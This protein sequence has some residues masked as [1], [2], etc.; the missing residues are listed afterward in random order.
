MT[1]LEHPDIQAVPAVRVICV[2]P[3]LGQPLPR[4]W[5]FVVL[6]AVL[7]PLVLLPPGL[8]TVGDGGSNT[9]IGIALIALA[10]IA[11]FA[12]WFVGSTGVLVGPSSVS[13]TLGR[14]VLF[15][16][17]LDRVEQVEVRL[18]YGGAQVTAWTTREDGRRVGVYSSP[19]IHATCRPLLDALRPLVE[20]RPELL[21]TES[22]RQQFDYALTDA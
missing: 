19:L 22:D 13:R 8:L 21:A 4:A 6:L 10:V 3:H 17:P 16:I 15:T 2:D 7:P 9:V 11:L 5:T 20:A 12:A 14:R 1:W 18:R